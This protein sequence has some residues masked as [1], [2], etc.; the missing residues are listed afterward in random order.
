MLTATAVGIEARRIV[1]LV[2]LVAAYGL[3]ETFK[4]CHIA[5]LFFGLTYRKVTKHVFK[6]WDNIYDAEVGTAPFLWSKYS[7]NSGIPLYIVLST[8]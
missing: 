1:T 7:S 3:E 8:M 6:W 4:F 2:A 5:K